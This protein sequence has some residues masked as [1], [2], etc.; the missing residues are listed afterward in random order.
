M[1]Q[2][3]NNKGF[4][5]VSPRAKSSAT[6]TTANFDTLGAASADIEFAFS[7]AINTNAVGP[8]ISVLDSDDTT[9]S[10]FVTVIANRTAESI[11]NAK[12]LRYSIPR[13]RKRYLRVSITTPAATNDDCTITAIGHLYRLGEG[14]GSTTELVGTT[15]DAAVIVSGL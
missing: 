3:Q 8:T 1:H 5:L 13:L 14:P 2:G 9:A 11:V 12:L 15:N 10:N 7:S 4:L 6:T